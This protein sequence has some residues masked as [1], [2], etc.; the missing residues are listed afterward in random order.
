MIVRKDVQGNS[1]SQEMPPF[2][3][4]LAASLAKE[5]LEKGSLAQVLS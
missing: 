1:L 3:A 4:D 2:K 5:L